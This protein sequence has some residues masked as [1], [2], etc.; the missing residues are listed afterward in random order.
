MEKEKAIV[1]P[2]WVKYDTLRI[3]E[4]IDQLSGCVKDHEKGGSGIAVL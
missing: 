1:D 4:F 3:G 2:G